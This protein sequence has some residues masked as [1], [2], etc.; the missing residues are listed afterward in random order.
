MK[1]IINSVIINRAVPGSGKTTISNT[2]VKHLRE[3]DISVALHSTDEFFMTTDGHYHFMND[4]LHGFHFENFNN[5]LQSLKT[6]TQVVIC[7]NINLAPWQTKPYTDA[8]REYNYRIIFI[9]FTPREL[10]K[11]IQS[12]K[13]TPEKPDAHG[14]PEDVLIRF[15]EEYWIYNSLLDRNSIINPELHKDYKWDETTNNRI[16]SGFPSNHFDTDAVLEIKP[17]E[18]HQMRKSI[19]NNVL[20]MITSEV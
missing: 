13:V 19:G 9:T 3:N 14:V 17:D 15:I 20:M 5:F 12:Q 8:A 2:I 4:L 16:E 7:D 11:H 18:Y 10:E 1:K 6:G